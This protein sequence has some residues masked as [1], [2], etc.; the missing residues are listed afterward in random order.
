MSHVLKPAVIQPTAQDVRIAAAAEQAAREAS[1][2]AH[3]RGAP[4]RQKS[5]ARLAKRVV[6]N[7]N[8]E[9]LRKIEAASARKAALRASAKQSTSAAPTPSIIELPVGPTFSTPAVEPA[10]ADPR[11]PLTPTA[12]QRE[13]LS[14]PGFHLFLGGGR[15]G[16]KSSLALQEI[17]RHSEQHG[18][19][20]SVLIVREHLKA[21]SQVWDELHAVLSAVY[22]RGLRANKQ[23]N[24]FTLP[25]GATIELGPLSNADDYA[26]VQGKSY[27]LITG[28]EGGHFGTLKWFFMLL[29]N[30]RAKR[31]VPT[32]AIL[33]ANPG[34]RLHAQIHATFIAGKTPWEPFEIDGLKWIW[35]PST[36]RDNP[37][38][39]DDYATTIRASARGDVE[40]ARAW[41]DGSWNINRGAYFADV[42]DES[43][44]RFSELPFDLPHNGILTYSATD[45]G[46]AS[47]SVS[48]A[49][50]HLLAPVAGYARGSKFIVDEVHSADRTDPTFS[51]G[52]GWSPG[53]LADA[54]NEMCLRNN[55]DRSGC[56]DNARG[57]GADETLIKMFNGFGF[58]L[59]T[60]KS[61]SRIAGWGKVRELLFNSMTGRLKPGLYISERAEMLWATLPSVPRD[62][63]RIEDLDSTAVDHAVDA[64]RYGCVEE[65]FIVTTGRLTGI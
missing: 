64:T 57:L 19:N 14:I 45:W 29:S 20:A 56:I 26:K 32:R 7:M 63:V 47:P 34:G 49:F 5:F 50:A 55:I 48:L 15:G 1:A 25:N 58:R 17:L 22:L 33:I 16:G 28:D 65:P 42:V 3:V 9:Q 53:R 38:L 2:E 31:G 4:A 60:P 46:T 27:S 30:L 24:Q 8:G 54:M 6:A 44:Q 37:H 59:T 35:C 18:A 10:V 23:T 36:Y 11:G 43:K 13:V 51:T 40:L 41:V 61:K 12:W 52:L 39:A 62:Q 21:L